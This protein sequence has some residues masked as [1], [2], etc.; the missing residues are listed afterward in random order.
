MNQS[1]LFFT[2]I[3][4]KTTSGHQPAAAIDRGP[5]PLRVP[6]ATR[7]LGEAGEQ[8]LVLADFFP[9]FFFFFFASSYSCDFLS[10]LG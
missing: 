5:L 3:S 1:G 8:H 10:S 7:L 6:C 9:L 2:V 4:I